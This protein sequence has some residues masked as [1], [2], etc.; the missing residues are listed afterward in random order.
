[1]L[2]L[3]FAPVAQLDRALVSE[4]KGRTFESSRAHLKGHY[5]VTF[6]LWVT[7]GHC[8]PPNSDFRFLFLARN[9]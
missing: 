9:N 7:A 3:Q 8:R 5:Q 6:F 2:I 1:M 4:T